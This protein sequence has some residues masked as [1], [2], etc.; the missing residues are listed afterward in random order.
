MCECEVVHFY[1]LIGLVENYWS[2]AAG[3]HS[4]F[5]LFS[6]NL[7][8][9]GVNG[10]HVA[11]LGTPKRTCLLKIKVFVTLSQLFVVRL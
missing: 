3:Y 7:A 4:L 5:A 9:L 6:F 2:I 1:A 10:T 11:E 8:H